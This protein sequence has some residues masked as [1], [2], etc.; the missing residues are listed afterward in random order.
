MFVTNMEDRFVFLHRLDVSPLVETSSFASSPFSP[1]LPT[2]ASPVVDAFV[3]PRTNIDRASLSGVQGSL[4]ASNPFLSSLQNNP[5]FVDSLSDQLLNTSS[6]T[7]FFSSFPSGSIATSEAAERGSTLVEEHSPPAFFPPA[8]DQTSSAYQKGIDSETFDVDDSSAS[9]ETVS[10]WEEQ[11]DAFASSRLQKSPE[12][13]E[14]FI[15]DSEK[16]P[17][18]LFFGVH[19]PEIRQDYGEESSL[20]RPSLQAPFWSGNTENDRK[21]TDEGPSPNFPTSY[22]PPYESASNRTF[23]RDITADQRQYPSV[24]MPISKPSPIKIKYVETNQTENKVASVSPILI[25]EQSQVNS[26]DV[27]QNLER[28][29]NSPTRRIYSSSI[30]ESAHELRDSTGLIIEEVKAAIQ[31]R[32]QALIEHNFVRVGEDLSP[33][34]VTN[35]KAPVENR[36]NE[37]IK[38]AISAD[39]GSLAPPKPPQL[40][41][42]PAFEPIES[43]VDNCKQTSFQ[44]TSEKQ[45]ESP[46]EHELEQNMGDSKHTHSPV[47][48]CPV[49]EIRSPVLGSTTEHTQ[50]TAEG[51]LT[52]LREG[53]NERPKLGAANGE[54][55]LDVNDT[56][57][58]EQFRTCLSSVSLDSSSLQENS[59][60]LEIIKH[61]PS[62]LLSTLGDN[63]QDNEDFIFQ[64]PTSLLTK[65]KG[66][67]TEDTSAS[68]KHS[69][70]DVLFWSALEEQLPSSMAEPTMDM[71]NVNVSLESSMLPNQT[72]EYRTEPN[73]GKNKD[74]ISHLIESHSPP[75]NESSSTLESIER[76]LVED[77]HPSVLLSQQSSWSAD[78][79]V[80]FKNE[81]FWKTDSDQLAQNDL[82]SLPSPGNPFTPTDKAPL[83]HKNPF[84]DHSTESQSSESSSLQEDM[85]FKDLHARAIGGLS[86]DVITADVR[87]P[88][89]HGNQPLAFSTPSLLAA[90]NPKSSNFPSPIQFSTASGVTTT[91]ANAHIATLSY[92]HSPASSGVT[93]PAHVVLPQET[94]PAENPFMPLTNR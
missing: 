85:S 6:P 93:S 63:K 49:I 71:Q 58:A 83:S 2:Q 45:T 56:S 4:S 10:E 23:T 74:L 92:L 44:D 16:N 73:N 82:K 84:A 48:C 18:L 22:I 54:H 61:G 62:D 89:V 29:N 36:V 53:N 7:H 75:P 52:N 38:Q 40:T 42:P 13:K 14:P 87:A 41:L 20:N 24:K 21:K 30:A 76:I 60:K 88:N 47:A 1:C 32:Q 37:L 26:E 65:Q 67:Q 90:P 72:L 12:T 80:D 9:P 78:I 55:L 50:S 86:S 17:S 25:K 39:I 69:Q 3:L 79:I 51:L 33:E 31:P 59:N 81:D 8:E 34:P 66:N 91:T 11:F 35:A 68:K 28:P 46:E 70:S 94:Q 5:F 27:S 43:N 57:A 77:S 15:G 19:G 64:K